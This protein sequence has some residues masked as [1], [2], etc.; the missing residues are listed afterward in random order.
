M[1]LTRKDVILDKWYTEEDK[2]EFH[3]SFYWSSTSGGHTLQQS[4]L[5]FDT[6]F[7]QALDNMRFQHPTFVQPPD[8]EHF[9]P[10]ANFNQRTWEEGMRFARQNSRRQ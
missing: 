4:V 3:D 2:K 10:Y 7:N 5:S 8:Y 1:L 6:D 9:L